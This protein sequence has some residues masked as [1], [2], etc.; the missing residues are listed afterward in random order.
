MPTR[1]EVLELY[2]QLN[3]WKQHDPQEFLSTVGRPNWEWFTALIHDR[4]ADLD[5]LKEQA[6][7]MI[8]LVRD[9]FAP[10]PAGA[11]LRTDCGFLL[12]P[13]HPAMKPVVRGGSIEGKREEFER[14]YTEVNK[15]RLDQP[16]SWTA[17]RTKFPA[18]EQM[19]GLIE[20]ASRNVES[21][22]ERQLDRYIHHLRG[23]LSL[24][25]IR[26]DRRARL[27]PNVVSEEKEG[28][29]NRPVTRTLPT[30]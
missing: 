26:E 2:H 23:V 15:L 9:E 22:T 1:E 4:T 14:L 5:L 17:F 29:E 18:L 8:D 25:Q 10:G 13:H 24:N 27:D 6:E 16:L 21:K 30:L 19:W 12:S 28:D 7:F 11:G 20:S 3:G